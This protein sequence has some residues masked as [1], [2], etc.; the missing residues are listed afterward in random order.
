MP[1]TAWDRN[2]PHPFDDFPD[3]AILLDGGEEDEEEDEGR[4]G[5]MQARFGPRAL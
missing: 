4:E 3:A 5:E 2:D 1:A